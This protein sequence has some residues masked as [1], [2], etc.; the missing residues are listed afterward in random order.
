MAAGLALAG[1][2][3]AGAWAAAEP[4]SH[5]TRLFMEARYL[6]LWR[7][8]RATP[9]DA[10]LQQMAS[11]VGDEATALAQASRG[12]PDGDVLPPGA[13]AEDA[14]AAIVA[15]ARGRR[16]VFLNEA[17]VCSRHR[18]FLAQVLRA[19]RPQGFDILAC[20]DFLNA[21]GPGAPDVRAY[22]AG[23]ALDPTLGFYLHDPRFAE[24]V[25]EAAVLGY[26]LRPYEQRRDQRAA[27]ETKA[28]AMARRDAAQTGNFIAG[29]LDS[30]PQSRVV[31]YCG[32]SHLRKT[33]DRRGS[34][35][36]ARR[37][38]AMAGID[39]L[40][41]SQ[42]YTGSFGPHAGDRPLTRAVLERF[43]PKASIVVRGGDGV[44]VAAAAAGADLAVFHPSLPDV[45]GR[46]GWLAADPTRRRVEVAVPARAGD[47]AVIVQAVHAVDKDMAVPADQRV[48]AAGEDRAVLFLRPG[49]YRLRLETDAGFTPLKAVT[50]G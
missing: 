12:P 50:V 44:S 37:L 47:A 21:D 32:Y 45:E 11:F 25:R 22:Q 27:G 43:A 46:P 19:L 2:A 30:D 48:V 7:A 10:G 8:I 28:E 40:C 1:A 16:V 33:P 3:P 38:A 35:W 17:H 36:F 39:P 42:A 13:A 49:D 18:H 9:D 4:V 20:E 26:R 41:V 29:V 24:A 31:V 6:P 14:L 23:G 15:A 5:Q 34:E